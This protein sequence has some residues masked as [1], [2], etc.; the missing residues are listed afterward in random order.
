MIASQETPEF[1]GVVCTD[2]RQD[3]LVGVHSQGDDR[4]FVAQL[5]AVFQVGQLLRGFES[6][7]ADGSDV[8]VGISQEQVPR[9][10]NTFRLANNPES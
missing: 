1:E 10:T 3:L 5:Q 9:L 6:Q 4:L 2:A 8:S 7:R